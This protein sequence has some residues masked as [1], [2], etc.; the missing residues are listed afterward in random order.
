MKNEES[1]FLYNE[2]C[3]RCRSNGNDNAGDNL[4]VFSDGHARCWSCDFFRFPKLNSYGRIHK[5]TKQP[6]IKLP[7]DSDTNYSDMAVTWL[8]QYDL[9]RSDM[10]KH[11]VL[12]SDEGCYINHKGDKVQC[13]SLLIFPVWGD[14]ELLAW[15][16]RYFG[17][18]KR[19]P[20]WIG[21]GK[22]QEVYNIMPGKGPLVLT[23]AAISAMK[24]N[25][26]GYNTM[27]L[28]GMHAK[29]RFKHLKLLGH[30]DVVLWLDPGMDMESIKQARVG[31]LEGLQIHSV[32]SGKKPKDYTREEINS[33]LT[34]SAVT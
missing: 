22:L 23:E 27:P 26:Y 32:L 5:P 1:F 20:K 16:G 18:D 21:R 8:K 6:L 33:F 13:D 3:P 4:G 9:T 2:T 14:G 17:H 10:L 24:V 30:T 11:R 29:A 34:G 25:K 28:Y 31:R 7:D 15:Q 12:W 19:V